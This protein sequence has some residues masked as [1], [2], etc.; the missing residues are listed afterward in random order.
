[1]V[2]WVVVG[3]LGAAPC[4]SHPEKRGTP[5]WAGAQEHVSKNRSRLRGENPTPHP[6]SERNTK[7]I[8][9]LQKKPYNKLC[10]DCGQKVRA[11]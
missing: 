10:F 9:D 4:G 11:G 6:M 1:V 2:G 8:K 7:I 5:S 3:H